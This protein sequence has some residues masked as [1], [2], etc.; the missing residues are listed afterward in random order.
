MGCLVSMIAVFVFF[1]YLLNSVQDMAEEAKK[2][3]SSEP[4]LE[5]AAGSDAEENATVDVINAARLSSLLSAVKHY[6]E[7]H[8]GE[9][10]AMDNPEAVRNALFPRYVTGEG[11]LQPP[12]S[13]MPYLPNPALSE[14]PL[15][16][17][18]KPGKII[19]FYEPLDPVGAERLKRRAVVFLD[20]NQYTVTPPEWDVLRQKAGIP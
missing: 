15:K 8:Q 14:K 19:A 17:F 10:P 12:G 18:I 13:R 9:L 7:D 3:R 5:T 2:V 16:S 1:A 6:A 11:V 20:G 4:R